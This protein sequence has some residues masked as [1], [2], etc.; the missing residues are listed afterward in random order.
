MSNRLSS[1]FG[2]AAKAWFNAS[3][4]TRWMAAGW[5]LLC[6][7]LL[8]AISLS[9]QTPFTLVDDYGDWC[10]VLWTKWPVLLKK[11]L[12][13][14]F[15]GNPQRYRP[16]FEI[17]NWVTWRTLGDHPGLHHLVRWI[18]LGLIAWIGTLV[19]R[20][21]EGR[22]M[23]VA[24]LVMAWVL[25][26]SQNQP[27]ARLAPQEL[28]SA[29]FLVLTLL[30]T[31]R[32]L[33]NRDASLAGTSAANLALLL[34]GFIGLSIAKESNLPVMAWVLLWLLVRH[35]RPFGLRT[36]AT[37]SLLSAVLAFTA[38]RAAVVAR[39]G[40]YGTTAI[41]MVL[42]HNNAAWLLGDALQWNISPLLTAGLVTLLA[43]GAIPVCRAIK[44]RVW[45]RREQCLLF[46]WGVLAAT[47]ISCLTSW[48]P[49][50]RYWYP[51]L[52]VLALLTATGCTAV[53]ESLAARA[54]FVRRAAA[55]LAAVWMLYFAAANYSGF[56]WQFVNQHHQ[57]HVDRTMLTGVEG[58]LARGQAVAIGYRKRD[59]EPEMVPHARAYFLEFRP[60]FHREKRAKLADFDRATGPGA[61][62]LVSP[63]KNEREMKLRAVFEYRR[64]YPLFDAASRFSALAQGRKEA[65]VNGDAGAHD[66]DY[67]WYLW[68][69][70]R[71]RDPS[72]SR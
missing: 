12:A 69:P 57:G 9:F 1:I 53:A 59:P 67:A 68:N 37:L 17:Y 71:D 19:L 58:L 52:V 38:W 45:L 28:N 35:S 33:R 10:V 54:Q 63:R 66:L 11:W 23:P 27:V 30:A 16:L 41:D 60:Y 6:L 55:G 51:V 31:V 36:A 62:W 47:T 2:L 72:P 29:L 42:L 18:V 26:L 7:L 25:L 48:R 15:W 22:R 56:L 40:G 4:Q 5:A 44:W 49:V 39:S 20:T 65:Y 13:S 21:T 3:M 46:L 43:G 50:L 24:S 61:S 32:L 14:T 34:S 70:D 64:T 8:P